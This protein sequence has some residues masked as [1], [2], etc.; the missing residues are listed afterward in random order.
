MHKKT[1]KV[2]KPINRDG[3]ASIVSDYT[4]YTKEVIIEILKAKDL[5]ITTLISEGYSVKDHKMLRYDVTH[6]EE[7]PKAFDGINKVYYT[8]PAKKIVTLVP[9]ADLKNALN[10]LNKVDETKQE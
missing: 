3:I 7:R 1:N 6:Q 2:A 9:L 4:G 10:K 8:I 5:A